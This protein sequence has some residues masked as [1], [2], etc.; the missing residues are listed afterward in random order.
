MVGNE[1]HGVDG[2]FTGYEKH[3]G[4]ISGVLNVQESIC[5]Y[6]KQSRCDSLLE[7]SQMR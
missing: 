6:D 5:A 1:L 3:Y 7:L 4:E 2:R